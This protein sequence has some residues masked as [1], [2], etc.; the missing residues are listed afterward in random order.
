MKKKG[1]CLSTVLKVF[2]VLMVIGFIAS[3]FGVDDKKEETEKTEEAIPKEEAEEEGIKG[4]E[5]QKENNYGDI[6]DFSY[7]I[8]GENVLL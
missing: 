1:S 7:E 3:F 6:E 5:V 8:S 4:I 2:V